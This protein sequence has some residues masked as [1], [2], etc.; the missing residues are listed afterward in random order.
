MPLVLCCFD[1]AVFDVFFKMCDYFC[2]IFR[3]F[4]PLLSVVIACLL[5]VVRHFALMPPLE[6]VH[7]LEIVFDWFFVLITGITPTSF[8]LFPLSSYLL[9]YSTPLCY[10][11]LCLMPSTF[12]RPC[13]TFLLNGKELS[14]L[15]ITWSAAGD[16]LWLPWHFL[17]F[18][19]ELACSLFL[20]CTDFWYCWRRL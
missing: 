13:D 14:C 5:V 11:L 18:A 4:Y 1:A 12:C 16:S 10:F 17:C 7:C 15:W 3:F 6:I 20:I 2:L 8:V 9:Y 19:Y